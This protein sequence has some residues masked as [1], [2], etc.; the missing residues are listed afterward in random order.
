VTFDFIA[1][2]AFMAGLSLAAHVSA[3]LYISQMMTRLVVEAR[4]GTN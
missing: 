4:P 1:A 3:D 2:W